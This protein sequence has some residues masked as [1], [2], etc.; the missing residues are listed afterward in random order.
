MSILFEKPKFDQTISQKVFSCTIQLSHNRLKFS[1]MRMVDLKLSTFKD[2]NSKFK[3]IL[4][5]HFLLLVKMI[6]TITGFF[7]LIAQ[8]FNRYFTHETI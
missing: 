2:V 1:A 6:A 5:N 4:F 8:T 7:V 3:L